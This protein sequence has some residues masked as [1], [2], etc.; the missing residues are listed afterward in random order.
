MFSYNNK[1]KGHNGPFLVVLKSFKD[2]YGFMLQSRFYWNKKRKKNRNKGFFK[3]A[4]LFLY[5]NLKQGHLGLC[6]DFF[7]GDMFG[8]ICWKH[9][10]YGW[11]DMLRIRFYGIKIIFNGITWCVNQGY[12]CLFSRLNQEAVID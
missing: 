12:F 8:F 1:S 2:F 3:K 11:F 9:K 4:W 5:K 7:K 10:D 6:F